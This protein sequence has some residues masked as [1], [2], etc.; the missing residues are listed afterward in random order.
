[1]NLELKRF[2]TIAI[3]YKLFQFIDQ[4]YVL[5]ER[6]LKKLKSQSLVFC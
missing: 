6:T 1:M 3:T 5:P 2:T 4:K